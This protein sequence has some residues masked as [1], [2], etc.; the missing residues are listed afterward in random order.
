MKTLVFWSDNFLDFMSFRGGNNFRSG[1]D[2][3]IGT[4]FEQ[5]MAEFLDRVRRS[6]YL[7]DGMDRLLL[8]SRT[9]LKTIVKCGLRRYFRL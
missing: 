3:T 9:T 8:Y 5:P 4:C 7:L 2:R 1:I 6:V